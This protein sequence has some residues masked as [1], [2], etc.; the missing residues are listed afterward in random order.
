M[1]TISTH[2]TGRVSA[3]IANAE[4]IVTN[5]VPINKKD[6]RSAP[7][8]KLIY[9]AATETNYFDIEAAHAAGITVCNVRDYATESVTQHVF[10]LGTCTE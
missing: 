4:I 1:A 7:S 5:K 6:L 10:S 2:S 8:L 9:I 3:R